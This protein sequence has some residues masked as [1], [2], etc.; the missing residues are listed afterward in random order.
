[1]R[2]LNPTGW[3]ADV[4]YV[5]SSENRSHGS[6]LGSKLRRLCDGTRFRYVFA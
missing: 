1:M 6:S 5:P 2:G 3:I 4:M